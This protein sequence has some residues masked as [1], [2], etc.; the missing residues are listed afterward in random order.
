MSNTSIPTKLRLSEEMH[1][2]K[3]MCFRIV[4]NDIIFKA[5]HGFSNTQR[6]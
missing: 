1:N 3:E 5:Y 4:S 6:A 2:L